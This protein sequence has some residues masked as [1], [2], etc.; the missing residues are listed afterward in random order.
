MSSNQVV[1][2][3]W[4]EA[5]LSFIWSVISHGDGFRKRRALYR[6]TDFHRDYYI[7]YFITL[8]HLHPQESNSASFFL[9]WSLAN[10]KSRVPTLHFFYPRRGYV[11]VYWSQ[12]RVLSSPSEGSSLAAVIIN[13]CWIPGVYWYSKNSSN[14][15]AHTLLKHA[16]IFY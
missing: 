8:R 1:S 7:F 14:S 9:C 10:T 3:Y 2:L 13:N 15:Y 11:T 6:V 12:I 5:T 16:Y 4:Y